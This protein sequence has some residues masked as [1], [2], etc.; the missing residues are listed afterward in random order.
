M[1][2]KILVVDDNAFN[3]K[4]LS[5]ILQKAGYVAST[6]QDG[7][8]VIK[9]VNESPPD[10]I[11]LDL[12][13][14][15]IDGF[16]ICKLLKDN[17]QTK[18][19]PIIMITGRTDSESIK[20]ALELGVFDY[21]KKPIEEIEVIARVQSTLRFKEQLEQLKEMSLKDGLTGLYN[22]YFLIE[23]FEKELTRHERTGQGMG[24]I[25]VDIDF[26][27]KVNDTYG[28][29]TGDF[30][31]K[32]LS[33]LLTK[34]VRQGD[35]VGRYGG[36]E[37][38]IVFANSSKEDAIRA[39]ERIRKRVENYVFNVSET[40]IRITVS[41]GVCYKEPNTTMTCQEMIQYADKALYTAK[42]NGR[43]QFV[44]ADI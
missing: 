37:F 16:E 1:S 10:I 15:N 8:Q 35:V 14:P 19:I 12:I 9:I 33:N 26:F 44:V 41:L 42:R 21:I 11:L 17:Y 36:E 34:S 24:F 30:V 20:K 40:D 39:C 32:K 43:N 3:L 22:H 7:S 13:M 5:D 6:T 38:G 25:M 28:H 4:L 31:L 27:K 23:L 18:D 2:D 29:Q